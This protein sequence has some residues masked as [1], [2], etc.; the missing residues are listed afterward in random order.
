M[1][2]HLLFQF[3]GLCF[4]QVQQCLDF[5]SGTHPFQK[6]SGVHLGFDEHVG[7]LDRIGYPCETTLETVIA[8]SHRSRFN[9][10]LLPQT[11]AAI[12]NAV[13][14]QRLEDK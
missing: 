5:V 12:G 4:C 14:R 13:Q 9:D 2:C 7:L 10:R 8:Q 6:H 1:W 11:H 3:A